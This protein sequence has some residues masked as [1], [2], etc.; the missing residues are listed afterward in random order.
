MNHEVRPIVVG[1]DGEAS[2]WRA[3]DWAIEEARMR[4]LPL[5]VVHVWRLP[6]LTPAESASDAARER[7][8]DAC[9]LP[10]QEILD[11]AGKRCAD[12]GVTGE[13]SLLEGQ[14]ADALLSAS[15]GA[16]QLVVGDHR[17][18]SSR[19]PRLGSVSSAVSRRAVVPTTVVRGDSASRHG[20]VV[21]GVDGSITSE[22]ALRRAAVEADARGAELVALVAWQLREPAL[23]DL[24]LPPVPSVEEVSAQARGRLTEVVRRVLPG[25]TDV[26]VRVEHDA[27]ATALMSAA[28]SAD[29]LVVGTRGL[30][31]FSRM[32]LGS[33]SSPCVHRA[34]CPV[35]VVPDR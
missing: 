3:L 13:L 31:G 25:R 29:L 18:G 8:A 5:R 1:V 27:P 4:G 35:Q 33:V 19:W 11:E 12:A 2:G 28:A 32:L 21:V 30:G 34:P 17:D 23:I 22:H 26:Q 9:R 24:Q 16:D 6:F 15:A 20:R 7:L 14:P 10:G